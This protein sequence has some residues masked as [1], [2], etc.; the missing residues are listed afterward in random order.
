M[1]RGTGSA[2][3]TF[4]LEDNV[5]S[6]LLQTLSNFDLRMAPVMRNTVKALTI[7]TYIPLDFLDRFNVDFIIKSGMPIRTIAP[8][9]S[10]YANMDVI[11]DFLLS[12]VKGNKI[13]LDPYP[14]YS[15]LCIIKMVEKLYLGLKVVN[16][17]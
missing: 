3:I 9:L 4:N 7:N 16:N 8:Y 14:E 5:K 17:G 2:R 1:G 11:G 12:D 10:S 6:R 15:L 13:R